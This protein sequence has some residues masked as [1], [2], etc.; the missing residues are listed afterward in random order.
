MRS[1]SFFTQNTLCD[2]SIFVELPF[3]YHL[4][5]KLKKF[6][7]DLIVHFTVNVNRAVFFTLV[8][9]VNTESFILVPFFPVHVF[10]SFFF[11]ISIVLFKKLGW[12][13]HSF[14]TWPSSQPGIVIGSRVRWVD[15]D[16][17][18]WTKTNHLKS[19]QVRP[20]TFY[21]RLHTKFKPVGHSGVE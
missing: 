14:K 7:D 5:T 6:W 12:F 3:H 21:P 8:I 15:P 10:F 19:I 20:L 4:L 18:G 17:P 9:H 11:S 2:L 16:Q 1:L 13:N